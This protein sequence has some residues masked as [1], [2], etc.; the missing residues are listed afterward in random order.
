MDTFKSIYLNLASMRIYLEVTFAAVACYFLVR[1]RWDE[2]GKKAVWVPVV[3]SFIGQLGFGFPKDADDWFMA[4]TMSVVQA[5]LAVGIYSFV[6]KYGLADRA[7]KLVQ[8]KME[9]QDANS[10]TPPVPKP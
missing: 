8:K 3:I 4:F 5:G 7:G 2:E 1:Q 9:A 10:T 6:D